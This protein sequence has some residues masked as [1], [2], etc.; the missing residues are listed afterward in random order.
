MVAEP[1]DFEPGLLMDVE[2]I[3]DRLLVLN[4]G[5]VALEG[6]T[7]DLVGDHQ[8]LEEAFAAWGIAE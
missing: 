2:R 5:R 1:T 6:S 7:D 8:T 3:S 4:K